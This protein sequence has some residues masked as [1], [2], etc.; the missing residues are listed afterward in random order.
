[1]VVTIDKEDFCQD[2]CHR[3]GINQIVGDMLVLAAGHCYKECE[4]DND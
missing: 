4:A 1:M 3:G 2:A